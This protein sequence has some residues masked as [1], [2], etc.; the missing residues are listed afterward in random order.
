MKKRLL[1]PFLCLM[2][3][4]G[5]SKNETDPIQQIELNPQ[6]SNIELEQPLGNFEPKYTED[7][8]NAFYEEWN[9]LEPSKTSVAIDYSDRKKKKGRCGKNTSPLYLADNGVTIKARKCNRNMIGE[10]HT[11]K[12]VEYE[13]VDNHT[14]YWKVQRGEDVSKVVTTFVTNMNRLF[15]KKINWVTRY[16]QRDYYPNE[17]N[18][19]ISSWDTSNVEQMGGMFENAHRFTDVSNADISNWDVSKVWNM[20]EMFKGALGFNYDIGN[21]DVSNVQIMYGMFS[22]YYKPRFRWV[23][24]PTYHGFNQDI[25]NWDVSNVEDMSYMFYNSQFYQDINNWDVSNVEDMSYMF[26]GTYVSPSTPKFNISS[27]DTSNVTNMRGMFQNAPNFNND[28]SNWDTSKVTDMGLMFNR[29]SNFN[30]DIS[31]WDVSSVKDMSGM[32]SE[33]K[34]FNQDIGSWD[35]RRVKTMRS[36]FY[37]L[38]VHNFNQDI[39]NWNVRKVTDCY[40]FGYSM[41]VKNRPKFR[42]CNHRD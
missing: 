13:I 4:L 15:Y 3:V 8:I 30:N 20:F 12:G 22:G 40:G 41:G 5:C 6:I 16:N 28:I 25:G 38:S 19:D 29:A 11:L 26:Y 39:S 7:E 14:L 34:S 1:L 36:M 37:A 33:A 2:F 32:F 9:Q 31:S 18:H 24:Y 17:F 21:W 27:W 35:V 42:N 10:I 23:H